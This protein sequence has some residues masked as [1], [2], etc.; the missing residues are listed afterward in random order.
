MI[1]NKLSASNGSGSISKP[2]AR[3]WLLPSLWTWILQLVFENARLFCFLARNRQTI[4][5]IEIGNA[6][7]YL[8]LDS[9]IL[10]CMN[11]V[12]F[13]CF[14]GPDYDTLQALHPPPAQRTLLLLSV[15][16]CNEQNLD[17]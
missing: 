14:R 17:L 1:T 2:E 8:L 6:P 5:S 11:G 4:H 9:C 15:P 3:Q 12:K 10:T 16:Q 7:D 13:W